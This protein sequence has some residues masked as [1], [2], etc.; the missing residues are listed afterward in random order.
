MKVSTKDAK[1][2]ISE[3]VRRAEN[4]ETVTITKYGVDAA[5][6]ISKERYDRLTRSMMSN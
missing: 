1:S 3:I 4:G 6:V 2:T 5:V